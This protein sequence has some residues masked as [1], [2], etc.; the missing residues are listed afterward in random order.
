M[1]TEKTP[2]ILIVD[3]DIF[4]RG[5]LQN[6]LKGKGY[7][8]VV[9]GE[10]TVALEEFQRCSPDLVLMDAAMPVMDGF[11]ACSELKNLPGG[12]DVP[13]IMIT[14]LDDEDSVDKA[15]AV[16]AA[17]YITK[18]VHW[19]V[20][21]HRIEILL[22]ARFASIA[23]QESEI[24]FRGIFEQVAIG[25]ALLDING[26]VIHSNPAVQHML[27]MEEQ[28]IYGKLFN[29]LF[30]SYD[31]ELEKKLHQQLLDGRCTH[32]QIEKYFFTSNS[33]VAWIRLTTSIVKNDTTN[34][35]VQIIE[36][37]TKHKRD[38]I[39]LHLADKM[40]ET[41]SD[42]VLITNAEG[43]IINANQ[44]FLS[45]TGYK[46]EDIVDQNPNFLRSEKYDD[47][48]Y[49]EMW[50]TINETG[51]WNGEIWNRYNDGKEY[52]VWM[53]MSAI[54]GENNSISH[55][56][57]VYSDLN[58]VDKQQTYYLT[59]YDN[60]TKLPN[61]LLFTEYLARI[62]RQEEHLAVLYINLNDF[63]EINEQFGFN[64]GDEA[65]KIIA[66]RLKSCVKGG[67]VIS[68][69]GG[70]K[71]GIIL[72]PIKQELNINIIA[73]RI[74]TNISTPILIEERDLHISC[75]IGICFC[76]D[77]EIRKTETLIQNSEV[78]MLK[79]KEI[80]INSYHIF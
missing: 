46:Y 47:S 32:Y 54:R 3:D 38:K 58:S 23:L 68:H 30:H 33:S 61:K 66:Q 6:L 40:F 74:I 9:A 62:C 64:N 16:G 34:F 49:T 36:N 14:S 35:F 2:L 11:A 67:D 12:A 79:A 57:A 71:F 70:D 8:V 73:D 20:L 18:P 63:K 44:S 21:R 22:K 55:Y 28:E 7:S 80:G 24:R 76:P 29:N 37:I 15:F 48:F 42:A 77:T 50:N 65:I 59:H 52:L 69:L 5:M 17:E 4:M 72:F 25:M 51:H 10:G 26:K 75:N 43:N 27:G 60:L 53:S 78:A 31:S 19:A 41:I 45:I 39:S 1:L 56:V 13:I